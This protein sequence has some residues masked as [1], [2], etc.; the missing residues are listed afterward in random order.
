MENWELVSKIQQQL[1]VLHRE[2]AS[3]GHKMT[4]RDAQIYE[5]TLSYLQTNDEGLLSTAVDLK[6]NGE[7]EALKWQDLTQ[8]IKTI[9]QLLNH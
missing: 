3:I 7:S 6:Q 8:K 4:K 1:D 2:R 9:E 5:L